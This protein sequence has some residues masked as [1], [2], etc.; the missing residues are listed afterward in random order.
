MAPWTLVS[1]SRTR[2]AQRH[3]EAHPRGLRDE[4]LHRPFCFVC[5]ATLRVRGDH[6]L[7]CPMALAS[8]MALARSTAL[9]SSMG[10]QNV[11]RRPSR[12]SSC[13]AAGLCGCSLTR[14][15]LSKSMSASGLA[16]R[17]ACGRGVSRNV[18]CPQ[19]A[20]ALIVRGAPAPSGRAIR[21]RHGSAARGLGE[22]VIFA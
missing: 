22:G 8:S 19:R 12:R 14:K 2:F 17:G 4:L 11:A 5:L 3:A 21:Q 13:Q 20:P 18:L 10:L 1:T 15:L 16:P 9:A 6:L 7:P